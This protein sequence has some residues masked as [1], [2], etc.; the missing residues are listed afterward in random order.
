MNTKL[1]NYFTEEYINGGDL[2]TILRRVRSI[3]ISESIQLG[4]DMTTAIQNLWSINMIHRDIKP[5][6]IMQRNNGSYVLLDTG[7]AFDLT[8]ESL[9][10]AFVT[11][12][13]PIYK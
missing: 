11:V 5:K 4:I 12:G 10:A 9:T 8:D 1:K 3:S 6:N 2:F 13:T 7:L